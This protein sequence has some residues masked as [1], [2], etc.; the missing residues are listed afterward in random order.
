VRSSRFCETEMVR[1]AVCPS[2]PYSS[3][4]EGVALQHPA[5]YFIC[6]LSLCFEL[7]VTL[8]HPDGRIAE[9]D[10]GNRSPSTKHPQ[11]S[12]ELLGSLTVPRARPMILSA[13]GLVS[14]VPHA[15]LT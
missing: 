7:R 10:V 14:I 5:P 4:H 11:A 3:L 9:V 8:R 6:A 15:L 1:A 2:M 12:R 13:R